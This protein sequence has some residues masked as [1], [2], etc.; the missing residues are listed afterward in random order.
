MPAVGQLG[1]LLAALA[2]PPTLF[3]KFFK[4]S[5]YLLFYIAANG[6]P[7]NDGFTPPEI[8]G[9][10]FAAIAA[11]KFEFAALLEAGPTPNIVGPLIP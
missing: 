2:D 3:L 6:T 4:I 5:S 8:L 1:S 9:P 10:R 7:N 11:R